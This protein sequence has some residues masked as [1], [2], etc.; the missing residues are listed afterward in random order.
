MQSACTDNEKKR[1]RGRWLAIAGSGGAC[2]AALGA[3]G[4]VFGFV[5]CDGCRLQGG[6]HAGVAL[7]GAILWGVVFAWVLRKWRAGE[8]SAPRGAVVLGAGIAAFHLSLLMEKPQEACG[9]CA[10]AL[11]CGLA[12]ATAL[13]KARGET[14]RRVLVG[15]ALAGVLCGA[16]FARVMGRRGLAEIARSDEVRLRIGMKIPS[17]ATILSPRCPVCH[18]FLKN[19][20]PE[21]RRRLGAGFDVFWVFDPDDKEAFKYVEALAPG[22]TRE[23]ILDRVATG[24]RLV[25]LSGQREVPLTVVGALSPGMK[26]LVGPAEPDDIERADRENDSASASGEGAPQ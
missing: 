24:I 3:F 5:G 6:G 17:V 9:W 2:L 26:I 18:E 8:L 10:A 12:C 20:V 11:V 16:G 25:I 1:G 19:A 15:V 22:S 14:S 4:S 21:L 23:E 7:V 13:V